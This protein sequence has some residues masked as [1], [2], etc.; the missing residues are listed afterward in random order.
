MDQ[1]K[2]CPAENL[3]K[4]WRKCVNLL[5]HNFDI[6]SVILLNRLNFSIHFLTFYFKGTLDNLF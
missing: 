2:E 5:Y 4:F 1:D 6:V 3:K